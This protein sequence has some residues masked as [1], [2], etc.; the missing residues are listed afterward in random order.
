MIS[1]RRTKLPE[2]FSGILTVAVK[3]FSSREY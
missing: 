3:P 1:W 2:M